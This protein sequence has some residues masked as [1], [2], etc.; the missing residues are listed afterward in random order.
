MNKS[1]LGIILGAATF[2]GLA[3][4]DLQQGLTLD[5]SP[6]KGGAWVVVEKDGMPQ[7]GAHVMIDGDTNNSYTT[8]ENGRVFVHSTGEA[9]R[10]L[11]FMATD[12]EGNTASAQRFIPANRS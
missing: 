3:M 11:T 6:Q 9:A 2:S 4:A 1:I 5:I 10:S 12:D 7:V 8:A